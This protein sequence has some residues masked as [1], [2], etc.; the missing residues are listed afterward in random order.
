MRV[1]LWI[2]HFLMPTLATDMSRSTVYANSM[3]VTLNLRNKILEKKSNSSFAVPLSYV[4]PAAESPAR[5]RSLAVVVPNSAGER[6]RDSANDSMSQIAGKISTTAFPAID[7]PVDIQ[8]VSKSA[9]DGI[10]AV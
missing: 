7:G 9:L 8:F 5:R 3:L 10:N 4:V 2:T 6:E 1:S